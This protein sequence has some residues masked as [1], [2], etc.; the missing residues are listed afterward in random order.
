MKTW[1]ALSSWLM[2]CGDNVKQKYGNWQHYSVVGIRLIKL[3]SREPFGTLALSRPASA[4]VCLVT[5]RVAGW[6]HAFAS[7]C[8]HDS[9]VQ[10]PPTGGRQLAASRPSTPEMTLLIVAGCWARGWSG[11]PVKLAARSPVIFNSQPGAVISGRRATDPRQKGRRY[12]V[13]HRGEFKERWFLRKPLG[14]LC[15]LWHYVSQY[16]CLK[17]WDITFISS[18]YVLTC[19]NL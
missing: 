1:W 11:S 8:R 3:L 18:S 16:W 5:S 14:L 9:G 15:M 10:P 7:C 13:V 4:A 19:F 6:R 2:I 12:R 17:C